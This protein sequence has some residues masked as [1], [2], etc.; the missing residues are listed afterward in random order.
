MTNTVTK[1]DKICH[2]EAGLSELRRELGPIGATAL[3]LGSVLGTGVFVSI[4]L[5]AGISG[6]Y[7]IAAIV[8]AGLLATVN[9]LNSAQLAANHSVSG[10]AYEYG[11]RYLVPWAGFAAGWV[12]IA[13]KVA[14]SA[15]AALGFAGYL[16]ALLALE[17]FWRVP[18]A[19]GLVIALTLLVTLGIR[20]SNQFNTVIVV[21]T[22]LALAAFSLA[23]GLFVSGQ[24][25][26]PAESTPQDFDGML[27]LQAT[28]IMFVAFTGYGRVA[29]LGEEVKNPRKHIP[30]AIIATL[31]ISAALYVVVALVATASVGPDRYAD[32][33]TRTAAPLEIIAAEY[34]VPGLVTLVAVGAVTAMIGVLLNLVL[35]ISRVVLSMGRRG[36]LP[37]AFA[38]INSSSGSPVN[39]TLFTGVLVFAVVLLDDLGLTWSFSAFTVLLYYGINN[40]AALMIPKQDKLFPAW[41]SVVGLIVCFALAWWVEP[42]SMVAGLIV[43]AAGACWRVLYRTLLSRST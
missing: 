25:A 29:T 33:S 31:L 3:G 39:A 8:F 43:L 34:N 9:G 13:A 22:L 36:D 23:G 15:A 38:S 18:L 19:C 6:Y 14:S 41:L 5:A 26:N 12:F 4:G 1:T 40:L 27:L 11:H 16:V 24:E 2:L 32:L 10:G 30:R 17:S 35:G 37:K 28:A 7:V 21:V 42:V 20:R